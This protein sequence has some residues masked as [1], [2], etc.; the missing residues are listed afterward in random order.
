MAKGSPSTPAPTMAVVLW[1]A[2][3]HLQCIKAQAGEQHAGRESAIYPAG[4]RMEM[5]YA[6][7]WGIPCDF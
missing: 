2:E 4:R 3:Y 7:V 1:N 6:K 5:A